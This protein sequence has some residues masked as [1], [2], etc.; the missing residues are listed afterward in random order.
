MKQIFFIGDGVDSKGM[1]QEFVV[2]AGATRLY[3]AT[4]DFFEWNNNSG[5]R[6]VKVNRPQQIITVK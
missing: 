3:V 4:W 2:P 5:T 6:T 1:R